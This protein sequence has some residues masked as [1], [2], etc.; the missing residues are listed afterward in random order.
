[1]LGDVKG[2]VLS[3]L[4]SKAEQSA[5]YSSLAFVFGLIVNELL[6]QNIPHNAVMLDSGNTIYIMPRK[7]S[8][9]TNRTAFLEM[10]GVFSVKSAVEFQQSEEQCRQQI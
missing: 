2:Y 7:F 9:E 1:M 4:D 10:S 8:T 3:P 6:E 5:I